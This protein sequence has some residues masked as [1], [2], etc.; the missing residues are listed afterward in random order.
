MRTISWTEQARDDLQQIEAFI[1]QD[2]P[3]Y[4]GVVVARLIAAT[5][6]VA[7]FPNPVASCPSGTGRMCGR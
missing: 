3:H 6:R 1:S 5:D 4:A 2:S 7:R